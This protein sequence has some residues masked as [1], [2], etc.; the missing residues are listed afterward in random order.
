VAESSDIPN[1]FVAVHPDYM[2]AIEV[3]EARVQALGWTRLQPDCD[4]EA[5]RT[6]EDVVGRLS[7]AYGAIRDSMGTG[8]AEVSLALDGSMVLIKKIP[9]ALGLG[10][11]V[12]QSQMRWEA[13][14]VLLS[15]VEEYALSHQRL[16]FSTPSGNP[17]YLQVLL[18]KRV[19]QLLRSFA[20]TAGFSMREIDVDCFADVRTVVANIDLD[21]K[22]TAVLADVRPGRLGFV[23]IHHQEFFLNTR[24]PLP[25]EASPNETA[26][27]LLKELR[28]LVFGHRGK[29]IDDLER[30]LLKGDGPLQAMVHELNSQVPTEILNPFLR[31]TVSPEAKKTDSY[32]RDPGR[33]IAPIG[34]ALK[35][36]PTL[37]AHS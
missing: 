5:F 2:S 36:I 32:M 1:L 27:I 33:F 13:E 14:Q 31:I 22:G 30:L 17:L 19:V 15:P 21:P 4:L 25:P 9:V 6:G 16:P 24:V 7:A 20:K 34:L 26:K 35:R 29:G 8:D 3:R 11:E 18:R 23:L 10:E 28:R 37:Q 12:V